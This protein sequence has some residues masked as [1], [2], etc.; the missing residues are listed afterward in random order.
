MVNRITQELDKGNTPL[1]IFLYLVKVFDTFDHEIMFYKLGYCGIR[2]P[3]LKLLTCYLYDREQYVEFENVKLSKNNIKTGIPQGSILSPLLFVIHVKYIS[4]ASQM[5]TAII[6]ADD[7]TFPCT[8]NTNG[9]I[10]NELAKVIEW[11]KFN[12]LS[13][14]IKKQKQWFLICLTN[15]LN[16][17]S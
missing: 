17:Q 12:K 10:N 2:G 5:F 6:Y 13:L 9:N 8:L 1:N 15:K 11:L 3:S 16:H 4:L 7:T 14:N